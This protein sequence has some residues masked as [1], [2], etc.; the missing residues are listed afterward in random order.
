VYAKEVFSDKLIL[1]LFNAF[2]PHIEECKKISNHT[3]MLTENH[4]S[5]ENELAYDD[6]IDM[7]ELDGIEGIKLFVSMPYNKTAF[8]DL[9]FE[10]LKSIHTIRGKLLSINDLILFVFTLKD[11]KKEIE[12]IREYIEAVALT[13]IDTAKAFIKH[14]LNASLAAKRVHVHRN[15]FNYRLDKFITNTGINIRDFK[16]AAAMFMI[17]QLIDEYYE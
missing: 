4:Y 8:L 6:Y 17:L 5:I 16:G 12:L 3:F 15:T 9:E 14:N 7:L 11:N 1:E 13:E 10:L 2:N